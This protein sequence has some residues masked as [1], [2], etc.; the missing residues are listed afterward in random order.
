MKRRQILVRGSAA[1]IAVAA[2]VSVGARG[3]AQQTVANQQFRA[4]VELVALDFLAIDDA[5]RPVTNLKPSELT[6]RVDGKPRP[7][8]N[9]QF[10]KLAPTSVEQPIVAPKLPP[11]Y[12]TNGSA[13]PGRAVIFVVDRSQIGM[14]EGKWAI[15]AGNHL[16]D[17]LA[18]TDRVGLVTM[19]E[20]RVEIDLTTR[21]DLARQALASVVGQGQRQPTFWT[22]GLAEAVAIQAERFSNNKPVTDLVVSRECRY[23][24]QDSACLTQ[25]VAE[26]VRMAS[27]MEIGTRASLFALRDFLNGITGVEGPKSVIFMSGQLIKFADT[28]Q[29]LGDIARAA[30]AARA[31]L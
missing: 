8:R 9:L 12:V 5:G 15:A 17:R 19:P 2:V 23:A 20:G 14:G 1:C 28:F 30:S 7:I 29:D 6:L 16:I 21:H 3:R 11:P 26:A 24:S 10:F 22:I 31:Q 27:E 25:V 13:V 18:P 4:G